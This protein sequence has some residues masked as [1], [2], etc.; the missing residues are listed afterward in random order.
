MKHSVGLRKQLR[1]LTTFHVIDPR[2]SGIR[3]KN[4]GDFEGDVGF[5]MGTFDGKKTPGTQ[6]INYTYLEQVLVEVIG[7]FGDNPSTYSRI[8]D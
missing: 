2:F 4:T 8:H 3:N 1:R 7:G 6:G 5:I